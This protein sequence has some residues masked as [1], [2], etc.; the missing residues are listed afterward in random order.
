MRKEIFL[1]MENNVA[2]V[3][4]MNHFDKVCRSHRNVNVVE[5]DYNEDETYLLGK[6]SASRKTSSWEEKVKFLDTGKTLTLKLDTGAECNVMGKNDFKKLENKM[7]LH[8]TTIILTNYN[9]SGIPV[10]GTVEL[11]CQVKNKVEHIEFYIVNCSQTIPVLG[12]PTI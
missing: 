4:K 10:L 1:R 7:K 2:T 5:N 12:L 6:I 11:N 3:K 8:T 9:G